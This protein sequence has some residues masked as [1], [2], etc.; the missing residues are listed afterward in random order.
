[1]IIIGLN[2]SNATLTPIAL[3][4]TAEGY[5]LAMA[6]SQPIIPPNTGG[7][8]VEINGVAVAQ[9]PN[10]NIQFDGVLTV[11]GGGNGYAVT[12]TAEGPNSGATFAS[13]TVTG[14]PAGVT[15]SVALNTAP[16]ASTVTFLVTADAVPGTY[17]YILTAVIE[18]HA[19]VNGG[20]TPAIPLT[21]T[22]IFAGVGSANPSEPWG[23]VAFPYVYGTGGIEAVALIYYESY[24]GDTDGGVTLTVAA[25]DPGIT[26][27]MAP[28]TLGTGQPPPGVSY[29]TNLEC[30]FVV[31]PSVVSGAYSILFT[32]TKNGLT[33]T[34]VMTLIVQAA[35]PNP[36]TVTLNPQITVGPAWPPPQAL[37]TYG[38]ETITTDA[39]AYSI[40]AGDSVSIKIYSEGFGGFTGYWTFFLSELS[41]E[42]IAG[43]APNF[44]TLW[45]IF[46]SN[47]VSATYTPTPG[48][49][50]LITTATLQTTL[51]TPPGL[52]HFKIA[53]TTDGSDSSADLYVQVLDPGSQAATST[54]TSL[55]GTLALPASAPAGS[56]SGVIAHPWRGI[57]VLRAKTMPVNPRSPAQSRARAGHINRV[58]A[59]QANT[60]TQ[61]DAWAAAANQFPGHDLIPADVGSGVTFMTTY[62]KMTPA[63]FQYMCQSTQQSFGQPV[64]L[65]P[66]VGIGTW[67]LGPGQTS[68]WFP[69]G[70]SLSTA[71]AYDLSYQV[72]GFALGYTFLPTG[73][74]FGGYGTQAPAPSSWI[75]AATS[76]SA[77][78]V[79]SKS[80][81]GF[82][83]LGYFTYPITPS[84][85]LSAWEAVYGDLPASGTIYFSIRPA[86]PYSGVTGMAVIEGLSY[87]AGSI[88]GSTNMSGT[89]TPASAPEAWFGPYL[90][91]FS[92][93]TGGSAAAG[94]SFEMTMYLKGEPD[95]NTP[96]YAYGGP[97]AGTITF[98]A[99]LA[100]VKSASATQ[101]VT[102]T[103]MPNPPI[104]FTFTPDT[105]T[106]PS[107]ST[108]PVPV[109]FTCNL[110]A[111]TP[112][113]TWLFK[114]K[115]TDAHQT[116]EK[117]VLVA[118]GPT[119]TAYNGMMLTP[120]VSLLTIAPGSNQTVTYTVTNYG[121][122]AQMCQVVL[123]GIAAF[124]WGSLGGVTVNP[125]G[126]AAGS[127]INV[128]GAS[129][130]TP[131]TASFTAT[132]AVP[133]TESQT[134]TEYSITVDS[135]NQGLVAIGLITVNTTQ[136]I[137]I[138]PQYQALTLPIGGHQTVTYTVS[139]YYATP[140]TLTIFGTQTGPLTT[141][142]SIDSVTVPAASGGTPGTATFTITGTWT[143]T[144]EAGLEGLRG[145]VGN[146]ITSVNFILD[147]YL[148]G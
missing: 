30:S 36:G 79:A 25:S 106:I 61:A 146:S 105:I 5:Q 27:T 140:Q 54:G 128:P 137:A 72:T 125:S 124:G 67:S 95:P 74:Y 24:T 46:P 34:L 109:T 20:L 144:G 81:S 29:V 116:V 96:R 93:P 40:T 112:T 19:G 133:S 141:V 15:A 7:T 77:G 104:T 80:G 102:Q 18:N 49:P 113:G 108:T 127:Y 136:G 83:V 88:L 111:G 22:P 65:T 33:Q 16:A 142:Q 130:S 92:S 115:A 53:K 135:V 73:E 131:G 75:I 45:C 89:G 87:K 148:A 38:G 76:A 55:S 64:T 94:S 123:G 68:P 145:N 13:L 100:S 66:T 57:Q 42:I 91:I 139:N 17:S 143:G 129:G 11:T 6:D 71:V 56:R 132:L 103:A 4:D 90:G 114:L 147:G 12:V 78:S 14:L 23:L 99:E 9:I 60:V 69:Q 63:Q 86:D 28:G 85:I 50:T 84:E 39:Y 35:I 44:G 3:S 118:C 101:G 107:G 58:A 138:S 62:L 82:T 37:V 47:A 59:I 98:D 117:K 52:Y 43:N 2:T 41:P 8:G 122:Q 31:N 110:P 134:Q 10:Q 119:I 97:Y 1:M 126:Y 120:G 21:V 70:E 48:T 26:A 51:V 121:T 32:A